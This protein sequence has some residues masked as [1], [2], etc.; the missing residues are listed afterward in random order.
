[1]KLRDRDLLIGIISWSGHHGIAALRE[2]FWALAE[3]MRGSSILGYRITALMH[4]RKTPSPVGL[5][6]AAETRL[7]YP[8]P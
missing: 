4:W 8:P 5:E 6:H 2:D 3:R 1:M 7:A